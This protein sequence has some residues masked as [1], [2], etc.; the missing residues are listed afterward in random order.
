MPTPPSQ[1]P[2]GLTRREALSAAPA[3][4]AA[5]WLTAC[6]RRA[7]PS[8]AIEPPASP[9]ASAAPADD[10]HRSRRAS[11]R[12]PLV[13][14]PHGGGPWPFLDEPFGDPAENERLAAYLRA[15]AS[16]P[17]SPPRALLVVSA[18]WEAPVATVTTSARPPLLYDYY[19]FPPEAYRVTWPAPGAP[20][21]AARVRALLDAAGL[22]SATDE[23]RGLDH[24][25]FVPLKLA[26]PDAAVPTLQLSLLAGLDP[27]AHLALGRALAPL[28]D[29]GVFILGSGMS[30]HNMAG[31]RGALSGRARPAA[32]LGAEFDAWLRETAALTRPERESRLARWT[33]A[34]GAR[35]SHPR[36]E[37]LL[38]LMVLAGAAGDDAGATAWSD[39]LMGARVSALQFG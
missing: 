7:S 3:T 32:P 35:A 21:V 37:H 28:R 14:L 22:P 19:G 15:L 5:L 26:Y 18:H 25:V 20:E 16:L 10:A 31:F 1:R 2:A 4:A 34:P 27:S 17:P 11:A 9:T 6:S 29:E 12:A 30:Y 33:S 38:P 24:G 36:E 8:A 39:T 13:Y 23:R